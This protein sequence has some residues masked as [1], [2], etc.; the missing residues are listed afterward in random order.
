M[1]EKRQSVTRDIGMVWTNSPEHEVQGTCDE[2]GLGGDTVTGFSGS[3][4]QG[5]ST[6]M[7]W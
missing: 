3:R 2:P 1:E 7:N 5:G 6:W 4:Q